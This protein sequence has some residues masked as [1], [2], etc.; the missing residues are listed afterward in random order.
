MVPE[1]SSNVPVWVCKIVMTFGAF[2]V[3]VVRAA[4][5]RHVSCGRD[6][7]RFAVVRDL[8][9]AEDVIAEVDLAFAVQ[10]EE[11]AF[12]L[13]L[14]CL[15]GDGFAFA[16]DRGRVRLRGAFGGRRLT[17]NGQQCQK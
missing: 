5:E 7:A 12:F 4:V 9:T 16:G 17:G 3:I 14:A 11:V 1:T 10:Q 8:I 15:D 6:L 13:L 2:H